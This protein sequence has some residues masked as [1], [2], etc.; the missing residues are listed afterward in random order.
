MTCVTLTVDFTYANCIRLNLDTNIFLVTAN[1]FWIYI[2]LNYTGK[3]KYFVFFF[4]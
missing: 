1:A 3:S 2:E 4:Q